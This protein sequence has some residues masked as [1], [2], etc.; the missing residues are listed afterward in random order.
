MESARRDPQGQGGRRQASERSRK[1]RR[2][3]WE[4]GIGACC[5]GN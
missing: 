5:G 4:A 1:T 3:P 2:C